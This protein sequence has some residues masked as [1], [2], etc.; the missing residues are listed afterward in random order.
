MGV[1]THVII[2]GLVLSLAACGSTAQRVKTVG[3]V[4]IGNTPLISVP[5]ISGPEVTIPP[6]PR[7]TLPNSLPAITI[8]DSAAGFTVPE[9]TRTTAAT[10]PADTAAP[11]T[12]AVPAKTPPPVVPPGA[13]G[14]QAV[15]LPGFTVQIPGDWTAGVPTDVPGAPNLPSAGTSLVFHSSAGDALS[16]VPAPGTVSLFKTIFA[17]QTDTLT[18]EDLTVDGQPAL[19][20]TPKAT[21]AGAVA[22]IFVIDGTQSTAFM[23]TFFGTSPDAA[24]IEAAI[25]QSVHIG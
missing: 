3:A 9:V 10:S 17:A 22:E 20:I 13:G 4:P 2:S 1:R 8:P 7:I 19:K 16:V 15:S 21:V 12:D 14:T 18:V 24:A 11:V 6:V 25:L 5:P 23:M